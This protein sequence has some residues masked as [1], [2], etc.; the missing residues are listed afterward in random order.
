VKIARADERI[1]IAKAATPVAR[2]A[3]QSELEETYFKRLIAQRRLIRARWKLNDGHRQTLYKRAE[4]EIQMLEAD[5]AHRRAY[6]RL[7]ALMGQL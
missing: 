6:A 2:S 3:R 1:A 5:L 7:E 4:A